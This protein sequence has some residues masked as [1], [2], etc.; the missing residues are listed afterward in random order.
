MIIKTNEEA[1]VCYMITYKLPEKLK[2]EYVGIVKTGD[3]SK[4]KQFLDDNAEVV[5]SDSTDSAYDFEIF[6]IAEEI[7][8][9]DDDCIEEEDE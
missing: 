8:D 4:L 1:K 9:E 5:S 7:D 2:E 6:E 3:M